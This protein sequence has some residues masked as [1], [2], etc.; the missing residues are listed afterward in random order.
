MIGREP[1]SSK[2]L[3]RNKDGNAID[4]TQVSK[5]WK[6]FEDKVVGFLVDPSMTVALPPVAK[7]RKAAPCMVVDMKRLPGV[8]DGP[9]VLAT[10]K[11]IRNPMTQLELARQGLA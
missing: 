7:K 5:P 3:A 11:R 6:V 2:G 10:P 8:S 1:F 4:P 9:Q